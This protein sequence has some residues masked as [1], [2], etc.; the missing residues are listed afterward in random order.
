METVT[1]AQQKSK[2]S[3]TEDFLPLN[4]TDHVEFYVGN[5]KQAAYFYRRVFGMSW[6]AERGPETRTQSRV[7]H[8]LE[9][10]KLRFVLTTGLI[11]NSAIV[12]HV[13]LHGDG[14]Q[15]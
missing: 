12:E 2:P 10:N 4:G 1:S 15:N 9:Q 11:P 13:Q 7:S 6:I 5:A 3:I 8:V 14:V